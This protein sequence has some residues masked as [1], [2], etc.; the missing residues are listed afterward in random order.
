MRQIIDLSRPITTQPSCSFSVI[1]SSPL[2]TFE[3]GESHGVTFVTSR[4]DNL[5]SNTCSHIDFPGHLSSLGRKFPRPIGAY[6]VDRFV[7][8]VLV[9]DFASKRSAISDFFD[10][11]GRYTIEASNECGTVEFLESLDQLEITADELQSQICMVPKEHLP[12][13]GI[14]LNTGV[15]SFWKYNKFESWNYAY[16]YSP[17]FSEAACD[18]IVSLGLSFVGIDAFQLDHPIINFNGHELPIVMNERAKVFVEKKLATITS[19][20]NHVAL[21]GADVL[22]YENLLI[23][24][25]LNGKVIEFYGVPLNFQLDGMNDNALVRPIA[26]VA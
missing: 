23:P 21:L 2:M 18:L 3:E 26:F 4:L 13:K 14:I 24:N 17:F 5:H 8:K 11:N 12:L 7:G 20:S 1:D 19:F 25:E 16:F 10:P 15:G 22:I 6:P 9:C